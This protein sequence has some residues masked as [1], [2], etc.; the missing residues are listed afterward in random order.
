M[1]INFPTGQSDIPSFNRSI[2]DQAAAI[3][4]QLPSTAKIEIGG[5]TD[6]TGDEAANKLLSQKR[7]EAV[8]AFLVK[9][10]VAEEMLAAKGYGSSHP[11]ASND[12][13]AGRYENR[14]VKFI[15]R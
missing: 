1:V 6:N 3:F 11:K 2:L 4:K 8:R 12:T 13:A 14:R 15:V 9:V 7:A 5:N 10:G